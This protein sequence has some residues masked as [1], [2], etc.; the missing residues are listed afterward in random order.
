MQRQKYKI[1]KSHVPIKKSTVHIITFTSSLFCVC[2]T[3]SNGNGFT[4]IL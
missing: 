2:C 3:Y 1:R 4:E